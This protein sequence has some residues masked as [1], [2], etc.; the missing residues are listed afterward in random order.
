MEAAQR[1]AEE[2]ARTQAATKASQDAIAAREA[3]L[4]ERERAQQEVIGRRENMMA[5]SAVMLAGAA[6]AAAGAI[7]SASRKGQ[8]KIMLEVLAALLAIGA[9]LIFLL[10]P[11]FDSVDNSDPVQNNSSANEVAAAA[12]PDPSGDNLCRIDTGLSRITVSD[13][14]DVPFHWSNDG[15]LNRQTQMVADSEGW[16]RIIVPADEASISVRHFD[17]ATGQYR[18][19]KYLVDAETADKAR[20]LRATVTWSG[21]T[22]DPS[23]I[24]ELGHMQAQIAAILP[25]QPNERLIY[26]CKAGKAP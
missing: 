15:C 5:L 8:R 1:L 7:H 24:A 20:M 12:V 22:A 25:P 2:Q 6:V 11:S 18:S 3:A 9:I 14:A 19:D 26:H 4:A 17:P 10:R 16:N 21:C 13:T 23:Q